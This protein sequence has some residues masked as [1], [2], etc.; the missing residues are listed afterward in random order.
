VTPLEDLPAEAVP[1]FEADERLKALL[2]GIECYLT[3][4]EKFPHHCWKEHYRRVLRF[5]IILAKEENMSQDRL[6]LLAA[7]ALIHDIGYHFPERK[8]KHFQ[9]SHSW[10]R[11]NLS[12]YGYSEAEVDLIAG[13]VLCHDHK[14]GEPES[15]IGK[16]LHD[17]DALDKASIES[18][19]FRIAVD[20]SHPLR[21]EVAHKITS[22]ADVARAYLARMEP[23]SDG[24]FYCTKAGKKYD[25]GRV[26][27]IKRVFEMYLDERSGKIGF[28]EE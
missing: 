20:P 17:A 22:R 18:R 23:L 10:A 24:G 6:P 14:V 26:E 28:G 21:R 5:S 4:G 15:D 13:A 11:K 16:I 7:A 25:A 9:E 19:L 27:L 1:H 3:E 8:G 12:S 2:S